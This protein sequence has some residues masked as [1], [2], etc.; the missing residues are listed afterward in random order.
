MG[1]VRAIFKK[2]KEEFGVS[3]PGWALPLLGKGKDERV[4][5]LAVMKSLCVPH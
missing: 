3:L 1:W 2:D 4:P 5:A